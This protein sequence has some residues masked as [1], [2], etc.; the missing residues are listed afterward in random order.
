MK[1]APHLHRIGSDMVASYLVEDGGNITIVD[2]GLPGLWN[3]LPAELAAMGRSL[4]DVAAVVLTHG[5]TDHLGFAE[6]LRRERGVTVHIHEADA[7]RARRGKND[8]NGAA[9][10]KRLGPMLSFLWYS[11]RRGGLRIP[12]VSEVS[13]FTGGEVLDVPGSPRVVHVP[14]HTDGSVVFHVPQV[15]AVFMGDAI[16]TRNVL[17]VRRWPQPAPFT[18]YPEAAIGSLDAVAALDATWVLPGHGPAWDGGAPE[19]VRQ[20]RASAAGH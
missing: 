12:P 6:R 17:T 7:E 13:T 1:I 19:A 10:P 20:V 9:G 4:A 5:D 8:P 3:E 14:G 11:S 2:A 18:L 16:T 15:D